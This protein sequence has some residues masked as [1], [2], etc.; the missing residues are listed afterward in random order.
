MTHFAIASTTKSSYVKSRIKAILI[1]FFVAHSEF[2]SEGQTVNGA[3]Y[4]EMLKRLKQHV[5]RKRP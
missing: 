1:V 3:F 4:V 2:V 5:N